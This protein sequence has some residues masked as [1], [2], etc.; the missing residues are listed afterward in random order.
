LREDG[1]SKTPR[2]HLAY[3]SSVYVETKVKYKHKELPEKE[4]TVGPPGSG[5]DDPR[6][7]LGR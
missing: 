5:L 4:V 7:K 1:S 3:W 6:R 2:G